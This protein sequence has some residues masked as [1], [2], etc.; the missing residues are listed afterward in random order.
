MLKMINLTE[1]GKKRAI[2][3][4]E[5]YPQGAWYLSSPYCQSRMVV[6]SCFPRDL[7]MMLCSEMNGIRGADY[8]F[9]VTIFKK[10]SQMK[11]W[12]IY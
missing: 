8:S 2:C 3:I 7:L 5:R 10:W 4:Y 1:I 9:C 6:F 12:R 11:K